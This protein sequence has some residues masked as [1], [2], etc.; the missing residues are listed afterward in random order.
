MRLAR[1]SAAPALVT[2]AQPARPPHTRNTT[3]LQEESAHGAHRAPHPLKRMSVGAAAEIIQSVS[4]SY[5]RPSTEDGPTRTHYS[6]HTLR[7]SGSGADTRPHCHRPYHWV[8]TAGRTDHSSQD[9]SRS[10]RRKRNT[11]MSEQE[12]AREKRN[13]RPVSA[14]RG[15]RHRLC[16]GQT[17]RTATS[18]PPT[19][20]QT[21][22]RCRRSRAS[23][24]PQTCGCTSSTFAALTRTAATCASPSTPRNAHLRCRPTGA[25]E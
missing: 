24:T 21:T 5:T 25:R 17:S 3:T 4:Q 11:A 20:A 9:S 16:S 1:D 15:A 8:R 6:T 18:A 19:C 14:R 7:T 2:T 10:A 13:T 23:S 12:T 22:R